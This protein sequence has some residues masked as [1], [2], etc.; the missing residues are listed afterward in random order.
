MTVQIRTFNTV[1]AEIFTD[2][3]KYFVFKYTTVTDL[4]Y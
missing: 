3:C 1:V 2:A 4:K